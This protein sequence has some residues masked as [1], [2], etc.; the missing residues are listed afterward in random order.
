MTPNRR[1]WSLIGSLI[2]LNLVAVGCGSRPDHSRFM[3]NPYPQPCRMAVVPFRNLSGSQAVSSIAATDEFVTELQQIE[4]LMVLPVNRVLAGLND[5]GMSE[6]ATPT[7]A[8]TLAD[9]LEVDVVI[10]GAINRY[11]PYPP[12]LIA[13]AVELY[14][15]DQILDQQGSDRF[16]ID[17]AQLARAPRPVELDLRQKFEPQAIVIRVF[18]AGKRE[19]V[20][21]IKRYAMEHNEDKTP[22]GWKIHMTQRRY[23]RF[24]SHEMIGELLALERARVGVQQSGDVDDVR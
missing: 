12:P 1:I 14:S 23:L 11:E 7:D 24:V 15:R 18:D 22:F 17:P 5:L 8:M 21:R 9:A 10:S 2:G 20:Q 16:H 13:M 6:V 19:T 4:G 3:G